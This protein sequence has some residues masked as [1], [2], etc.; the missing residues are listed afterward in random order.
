MDEREFGSNQDTGSE[1]AE[2]EVLSS[3]QEP[4]DTTQQNSYQ[5]TNYQQAYT[6]Y[7]Y[8]P[9]GVQNNPEED[10]SPLTLGNYVVLLLIYMIPCCVGLG[11]Y[12]Y[13]SFANGVNTN[14]RNFCRAYLIVTIGIGIIGGILYV[15]A[16]AGIMS[17]MMESGM[18]YSDL[19]Y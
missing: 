10:D 17:A 13:W 14:K 9:Q 16:F 7:D 2:T 6:N 19:Y 4:S 3:Y 15:V 1:N 18:Y 5:Q 12:I 11:F 8:S